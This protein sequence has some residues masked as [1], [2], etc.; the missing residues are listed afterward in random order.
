MAS[1]SPSAPS[2]ASSDCKSEPGAFAPRVDR[3]KCE[4]KAKCVEVCPVHVFEVRRID[5]ADFAALG[6][7]AKLKSIAHGRKT[8][9]TP[10]ASACEACGLC[11]E[12]CPEKAIK[13]ARAA[14]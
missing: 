1:A 4:G 9:Y 2:S 10:G 12:A 14:I 7:L 13:L 8:A 5:D 11:V 3:S 6:V